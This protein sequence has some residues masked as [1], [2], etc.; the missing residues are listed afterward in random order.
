MLQVVMGDGL[1]VS[2]RYWFFSR[3]RFFRV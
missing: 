1:A 2:G 3:M